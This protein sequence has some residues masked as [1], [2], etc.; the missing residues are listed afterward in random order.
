MTDLS[1]RIQQAVEKSGKSQKKIAKAVG[2]T[3]VSLSR[4]IHGERT[5]RATIIPKLAEAC[6]VSVEWLQTGKE[7]LKNHVEM[8]IDYVTDGTDFRYHENHGILVRCRDCAKWHVDCLPV[9]EKHGCDVMSD[10]T[11]PDFYCGSAVR[12]REND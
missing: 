6:G 4:Y 11:E 12:R 5:P 10:Y 8:I 9:G 3:E 2:I 1:K 7:P